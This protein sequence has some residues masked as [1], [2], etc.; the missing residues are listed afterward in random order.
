MKLSEVI[1]IWDEL[2]HLDTGEVDFCDFSDAIEKA[3]ITIENDV[4][5]PGLK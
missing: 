3:G 1:A 2:H 5:A 4:T